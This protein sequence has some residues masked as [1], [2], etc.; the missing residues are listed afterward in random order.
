MAAQRP[1]SCESSLVC[2]LTAEHL[3]VAAR[4]TASDLSGPGRG[5]P[6]KKTMQLASEGLLRQNGLRT[7]L[8]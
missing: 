3:E 6:A 8:S 7:T 5:G 4:R 1:E 2:A